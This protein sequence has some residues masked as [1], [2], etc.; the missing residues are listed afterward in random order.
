MKN[1]IKWIIL[2]TVICL[3][4][5]LY[6][7]NYLQGSKGSTNEI[8]LYKLGKSLNDQFS[9]RIA[10]DIVCRDS[11]KHTVNLSDLIAGKKTLIYYYSELHCSSCYEKQLEL[12]EK[13]FSETTYP[14]IVLASYSSH[15]H[16]SVY[17]KNT[18]YN[19]PVYQIEHKVFDRFVEDR[20][21]PY[22]FV[23]NPDMTAAYFYIPNDYPEINKQYLERIKK[24]LSDF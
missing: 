15:R 4:G 24:L 6:I 11:T 10:P 13:S 20:G 1:N 18:P 12:L 9:G 23:L 7:I 5:V 8:E 2:L 19:L 17:I 16:F 21:T 14:V 22:C 3:T